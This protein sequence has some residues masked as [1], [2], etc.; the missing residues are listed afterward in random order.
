MRTVPKANFPTL[1][2]I[3]YDGRVGLADADGRVV[4]RIGRDAWAVLQKIDGVRSVDAIMD[5]V[6]LPGHGLGDEDAVWRHLDE[7]AEAGLIV[8]LAPPAATSP[9][10]RREVLSRALLAGG[11]L[12]LAAVAAPAFAASEQTQKR[13]KEE[14][15]KVKTKSAEES[16][17][18][19]KSSQESDAKHRELSA[20]EEA[21]KR[22][23]KSDLTPQPPNQGPSDKVKKGF[24]ED[25]TAK[26][27]Q[28]K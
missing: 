2:P 6:E 19:A 16:H 20:R 5:A 8:R 4:A 27:E 12:G 28:K 17:V 22:A 21:H 23:S 24:V 18:K 11:A 1:T 14:R 10:R 7:L 25:K 26:E 3:E 9:L 13:G 15:V